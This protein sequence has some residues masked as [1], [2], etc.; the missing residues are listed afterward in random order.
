M[1]IAFPVQQFRC[2]ELYNPLFSKHQIR[3][4]MARLDLIHPVVSGNKL[5]KL[6]YFLQD[7]LEKKIPV[8]SFGGAYSNHLVELAWY[9]H[10]LKI[11][12][13]GVVRGEAVATLSHTLK[14]CKA[15][16]MKLIFVS[17]ENYTD[18]DSPDWVQ[19]NIPEASN[20]MIIPEGGYDTL[21]ARGAAL[22]MDGLKSREA[23]HIC[24][25]IGTA[26]TIAGLCAA[27]EDHQRI[28][29]VP[30]LKN[31][32]D[33]DDSIQHLLPDQKYTQPAIWE[34]QLAPGYAKWNEPLISFMNNWYHNHQIPIDFVYTAKML[35]TVLEKIA[36]GFFE[37]GS[38][39]TC[40]HTGGLQGN[41][42]LPAG[43]LV[44]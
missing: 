38:C 8:L 10:A 25:A 2:D 29:G 13:T 5:F 15:Y 44:F 28:I 11:P 1:Q 27:A 16:G 4:F 19:R 32:N 34:H 12:C 36:D 41:D 37:A 35:H 17:R 18:K 42:S 9:C 7:A 39:V 43:K 30:A 40:L 23:S 21:G 22:I 26:T 31:W 20:G 3:F 6:T 33:I 14:A 24:T